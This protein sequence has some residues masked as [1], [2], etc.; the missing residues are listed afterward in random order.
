MTDTIIIEF[1]DDVTVPTVIDKSTV[2]I[3][4]SAITNAGAGVTGSAIAN[5][6]DVTVELVG[7]P[8]D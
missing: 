6:L 5:P 4:A 7:T 1:E 3:T 8:K 2:T